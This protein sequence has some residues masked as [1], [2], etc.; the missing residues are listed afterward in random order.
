VHEVVGAFLA[1]LAV[2]SMLPRHSPVTGHVLFIGESFFI[3]VFLLYSGLITDP[4]TFLKSPQTIIVA[5]G[6]TV[7]AYIS[8]LI[9]AWITAKIYKYTRSEFWTVYGLSHAQAR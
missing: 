9:A 6:V 2:N 3:P 1:G 7:V 5:L 8:K 4:L